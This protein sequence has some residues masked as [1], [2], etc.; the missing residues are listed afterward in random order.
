MIVTRSKV[1]RPVESGSCFLSMWVKPYKSS[2]T[3]QMDIS[4][5]GFFSSDDLV[6]ILML[7]SVYEIR[8]WT[9]TILFT[10]I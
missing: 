8:I 5:S 4:N 1:N 2:K 9:A 6:V 3:N 10:T 7:K